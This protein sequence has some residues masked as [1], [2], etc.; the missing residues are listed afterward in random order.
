MIRKGLGT[1][2][3]CSSVTEY[4]AGPNRFLG[5]VRHTFCVIIVLGAGKEFSSGI[6]AGE[7][8]VVGSMRMI[9]DR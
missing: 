7:L 2:C 3:K 4:D 8:A 6:Q 5:T 9:F 1:D